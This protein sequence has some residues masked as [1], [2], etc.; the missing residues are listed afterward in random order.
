MFT[1]LVG[2]FMEADGV[3]KTGIVAKEEHNTTIK[4]R[5]SNVPCLL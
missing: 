4:R 3:A 2:K 5:K 1:A